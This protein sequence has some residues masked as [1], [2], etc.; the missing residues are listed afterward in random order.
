VR[1]QLARVGG[2]RLEQP[3]L[4]G[5][6]VDGFAVAGDQ[7]P[8]PVDLQFTHP[9]DRWRR[10][11]PKAA[12][13]RPDAGEQFPDAERLLDIVVRTC[14]EGRDLVRLP[15]ADREDDHSDIGPGAQPAEHFRTVHVGEAQVE[16]DDIRPAVGKRLQRGSAVGRL[17]D[18]VAVGTQADVE[19]APDLRLVV[20]DQDA[21][22]RS[23]A[24][25][26]LKTMVVPPPGVVSTRIEPRCAVTMA[27]AMASPSPE[28]PRASPRSL[29]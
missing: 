15:G 3:V 11:A 22:H 28:P 8:G 18:E 19:G 6:Q 5:R 9:Q 27:R 12:P 10:V 23:P 29:R 26:R 24:A 20:D 16:D 7:G 25:G 17:P 14:V 21:R 13:E 4:G 1:E 2:H